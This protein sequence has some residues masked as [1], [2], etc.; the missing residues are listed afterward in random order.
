VC[1]RWPDLSRSEL[2]WTRQWTFWFRKRREI[3]ISIWATVSLFWRFLAIKMLYF[4]RVFLTVKGS[5]PKV[6]ISRDLLHPPDSLHF[7]YFFTQ[8]SSCLFLLLSVSGAVLD[9]IPMSGAVN[10]ARRVAPIGSLACSLTI[11]FRTFSWG[12]FLAQICYQQFP[13]NASIYPVWF[14]CSLVDIFMDFACLSG[15]FFFS[16]DNISKTVSFSFIRWW[17]KVRNLTLFSTLAELVLNP[18]QYQKYHS[19]YEGGW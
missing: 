10:H 17:A 19:E 18:G 11:S 5:S 15:Q 3:C 13:V 6:S 7:R 2:L 14:R 12:V 9:S 8:D 1:G 16:S 4:L